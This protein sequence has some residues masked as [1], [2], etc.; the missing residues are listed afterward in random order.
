MVYHIYKYASSEETLGSKDGS[1]TTVTADGKSTQQCDL[2]YLG[3]I[4]YYLSNSS[5]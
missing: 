4:L 1:F 5:L 2:I 3:C